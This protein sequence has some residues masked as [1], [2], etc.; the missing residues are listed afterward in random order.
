V[1]RWCTEIKAIDPSD[2]VMKTWCGPNV[3]GETEDQARKYCDDN[4]LGY[5][6]IIGEL[7]CEIPWSIA[8]KASELYQ[9]RDN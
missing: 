7:V 2:Q 9:N 8:E 1:K 4:G 6:K 5:C 3:P